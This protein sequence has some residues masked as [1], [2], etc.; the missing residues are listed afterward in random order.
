METE[1]SMMRDSAPLVMTTS[2]SD[3]AVRE[4]AAFAQ[5]PRAQHHAL[6]DTRLA[7][8]HRFERLVELGERDLGEESEAAE[9]DAENRHARAGLRRSG[10]PC[11]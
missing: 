8:E 11:R 4:D 5:R 3:E 6:V 7:V 10:R 1:S 2:L 9:V